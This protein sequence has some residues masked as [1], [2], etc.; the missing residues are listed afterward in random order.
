MSESGYGTKNFGNVKSNKLFFYFFT[1]FR[2]ILEISTDT[3]VYPYDLIFLGYYPIL[4]SKH[5][6]S[7]TP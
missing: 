3:T 5:S 6:M 1:T 7:P 4:H 2:V